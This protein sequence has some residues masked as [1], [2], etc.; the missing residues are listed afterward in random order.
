M[1][2]EICICAAILDGTGKIW[3]GHR[4][5]DAISTATE[6]GVSLLP[7]HPPGGWQGFV[8]SRNRFVNREEGMQLQIKAGI[9]S[10]DR[11]GYRGDRLFSEDLY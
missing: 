6:A 8:T 9:P 11:G 1:D 2:N 4:H 10:S 5:A 3:R 7:P